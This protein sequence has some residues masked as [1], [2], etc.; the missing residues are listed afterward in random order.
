MPP[1]S[2]V[3]SNVVLYIVQRVYFDNP[4]RVYQQI[5]L[6]IWLC[7]LDTILETSLDTSDHN[8]PPPPFSLLPQRQHHPLA[9]DTISE[10]VHEPTYVGM[11]LAPVLVPHLRHSACPHCVPQSTFCKLMIFSRIAISLTAWRAI[12]SASSI[13]SSAA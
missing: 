3:T 7:L 12:L 10:D 9:K 6:E 4:A 5:V 2:F 8:Q 13:A 1:I 11:H